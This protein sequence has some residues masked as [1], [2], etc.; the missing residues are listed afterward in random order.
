MNLA[1]LNNIQLL[2]RLISCTLL[3]MACE[4]ATASSQ[5]KIE[6]AWGNRYETIGQLAAGLMPNALPS[7]G[8]IG[9]HNCE[10]SGYT[11]NDASGGTTAKVPR[12]DFSGWQ[13][14]H[15]S[16]IVCDGPCRSVETLWL[17][18]TISTC[19]PG[20]IWYH[21][22]NSDW[23]CV[24]SNSQNLDNPGRCSPHSSQP[25][26]PLT[27]VQRH[28]IPLGPAIGG[29]PLAITYDTRDQ[30]PETNGAV[31]SVSSP[32]PSFGERW[33]S[34]LH[35]NLRL[36]G[37]NPVPGAAHST[38]TVHRGGAVMETFAPAGGTD[39]C[40]A[41]TS[42][43]PATYVSHTDPKHVVLFNGLLALLV[44]QQEQTE[45]GFDATG[46]LTTLSQAQGGKLTFAYSAAVSA[47]APAVGLLMSVT[48]QF[49]RS[50]KF[51]YMNSPVGGLGPRITSVT[52]PDGQ[53]IAAGYD[54]DYGNLASLTWPDQHGESFAYERNDL[55]WALTGIID[56]NNARYV[57]LGYDAVG[58]A[59]ASQSGNGVDSYSVQYDPAPGVAPHWQISEIFN[60]STSSVCRVRQ[61][62]TPT[63]QQ[64]TDA[65]GQLVS[66]GAATI[67]GTPL[68]TGQS[69]PGGSGCSAS[70]SASGYDL[71]GNKTQYDDFNGNRSCFAYDLNRNLRT[72]TVEGLPS[73][74]A[75]AADLTAYAPSTADVGHPERKITTS[76]HPDWALKTREAEPRRI[77]TWVYNGQPDPIAGGTANCAP[78]APAL[79]DGKPIAVLC[80]RYEQA[81]TDPTGALGVSATTTGPVR[82]WMY[83]Y[84][85]FGQ[86]LTETTP[87]LSPT[88]ALS[89][90]TTYVYYG[91]TSMNANVGHTIGDLKSVTNPLQQATNFTS[92]DGAGRLLSSNDA[93]GVV[94]T[95][96]YWP[97]GWLKSET[98][99]PQGAGAPQVTMYDYWP[100]GLLKT[101]TLP[102]ASTLNYAYDDAHRLTDITDSAGNKVH[103]V[104]DNVGNRTSEQVT[105][106]SGNLASTVTR[107]FDALNRVQSRT[108]LAH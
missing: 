31:P 79:P 53:S 9:Y 26:Y 82:A 25:V 55:P 69:Q 57:T 42:D 20:Q 51:E 102:D 64:I 4:P 30:L 41:S 100:T 106:A 43:G 45:Q 107:V 84:N 50:V 66:I 21:T 6:D 32:L 35:R 37:P 56:E 72:V 2:L 87:K 104:L 97:R 88:D 29:V 74:K 95:Q 71:A 86:M 105:D 80:A 91:D 47:S 52:G 75:C 54:P 101:V 62:V 15:Y 48:D 59:N 18:F 1:S 96:T 22:S 67:R 44:D 46:S 77:A 83:T 108:G 17:G 12:W 61:W 5:F 99:T 13:G 93:N 36:Q 14:I 10:Y 11:F 40:G 92:Y 89:H 58:R 90:T 39:S 38:V 7:C 78:T 49:G 103:Y 60:E 63:Q 70:S 34:N 19:A 23:R 33:Q 65:Q 27:G 3:F 28:D 94:T 8:Y 16:F 24:A 81:T 85:Q 76:W 68:A 73:S 98:V